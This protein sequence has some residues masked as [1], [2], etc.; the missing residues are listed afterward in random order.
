MPKAQKGE[1]WGGRAKG[2]KNKATV[3]RERLA[4]AS[5]Q[6]KAKATAPRKLAKDQLAELLPVTMGIVAMYQRAAY[7]DDGSGR[8]G[9]PNHDP[10]IWRELGQWIELARRVGDTA[11]DY[12]SPKYRAIAV[13]VTPEPTGSLPPPTT[14]EHEPSGEHDR[15]R[16][17]NASYLKLVKG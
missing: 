8:P 16:A 13:A 12:E 7:K 3:E 14:V 10:K 5:L 11:A 17:A 1:R 4:L 15:E 9:H 6:A 2:T